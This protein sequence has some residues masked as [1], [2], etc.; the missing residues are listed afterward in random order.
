MSQLYKWDSEESQKTY[1]KLYP[2]YITV[3]N[4]HLIHDLNGSQNIGF[5]R[6]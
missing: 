5:S 6:V 4:L 1:V 2:I 3:K